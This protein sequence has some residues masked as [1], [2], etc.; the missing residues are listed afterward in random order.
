MLE[1]S[2]PAIIRKVIYKTALNSGGLSFSFWWGPSED[3][4]ARS[5]R[6]AQRSGLDPPASVPRVLKAARN[7]P[8]PKRLPQLQGWWGRAGSIRGAPAR[9]RLLQTS[10]MEAEL[11]Q[12]VLSP[13]ASLVFLLPPGGWLLR[14]QAPPLGPM[15]DG[16]SKGGLRGRR[17]LLGVARSPGAPCAPGFR[18]LSV[19]L[20]AGDTGLG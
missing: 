16:V 15:G 18:S 11:G 17:C 12:T 20:G 9:R 19:R 13:S 1:R 3:S 6:R 8:H 2:F 14:G 7:L 5:F 4:E 10:K